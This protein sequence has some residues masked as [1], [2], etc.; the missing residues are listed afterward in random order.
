[1]FDFDERDLIE[2]A[3]SRRLLPDPLRL[4][5]MFEPL[6]AR[7][8]DGFLHSSGNP[9]L[10]TFAE[11]MDDALTERRGRALRRVPA[12]AGRAG[13]R[14]LADGSAPTSG[15]RSRARVG[16]C[17]GSPSL[18]LLLAVVSPAAAWAATTRASR[19]R[20]RRPGRRR[21]RRLPGAPQSASSAGDLRTGR[22]RR[23]SSSGRCRSHASRTSELAGPAE[24]E[25]RGRPRQIDRLL[26]LLEQE[27]ELQRGRAGSG[28]AEATGRARPVAR[29]SRV[30]R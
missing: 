5:S 3:E 10:P 13:S 19:R 1:M 17:S 9:K 27:L 2:L 29:S 4:G 30:P 8:W 23:S 6:P 14:P 20:L 26:A 18:L 12:A 16:A 7:A 24:A 15:P 28:A 21:L 25:R 22:A 11:A